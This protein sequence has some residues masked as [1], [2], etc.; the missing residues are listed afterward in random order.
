ME[1]HPPPTAIN[2][3]EPGDHSNHTNWEKPKVTMP[4]QAARRTEATTPAHSAIAGPPSRQRY[5]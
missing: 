2:A 3:A 1:F 5:L 4:R